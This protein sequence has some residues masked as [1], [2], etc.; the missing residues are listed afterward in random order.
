MEVWRYG[1]A[2][3]KITQIWIGNYKGYT[4]EVRICRH[5]DMELLLPVLMG[6]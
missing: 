4:K 5:K 2:N 6:Q 1:E 3:T